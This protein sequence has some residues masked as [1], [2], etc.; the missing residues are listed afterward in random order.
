MSD[1]AIGTPMLFPA[2]IV[3]TKSII[4]VPDVALKIPPPLFNAVL[5]Q[6]LPVMVLFEIRRLELADWKY[7]PPP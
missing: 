2:T 1:P 3:L 7:M 5:V 4:P 6:E